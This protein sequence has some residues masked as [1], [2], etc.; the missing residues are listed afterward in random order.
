[1]KIPF[2]PSLLL[3]V[4]LALLLSLSAT[5]ATAA[6][7]PNILI[8]FADD[9]RADTIGAHG[10]AHIKTPVIDGLVRDGTS[11]RRNYVMGCNSGAVCAPNS[12]TRPI[13]D[14]GIGVAGASSG[15]TGPGKG[16]GAPSAGVPLVAAPLVTSAA[17]GTWR[18]RWRR[19]S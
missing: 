12:R 10:N 9:Q 5:A 18:R 15:A 3:S 16:G 6:T 11:F 7:K 13:Q 2:S 19:A 8:L 14:A 1:M 17:V 4:S